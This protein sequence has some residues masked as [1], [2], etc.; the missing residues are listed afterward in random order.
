MARKDKR[1]MPAVTPGSN[2]AQRQGKSIRDSVAEQTTSKSY[3][4]RMNSASDSVESLISYILLQN[5]DIKVSVYDGEATELVEDYERAKSLGDKLVSETERVKAELQQKKEDIPVMINKKERDI[6]EAATKEVS[7]AMQAVIDVKQDVE[8]KIKSK[9]QSIQAEIDQVLD[10][11]NSAFDETLADAQK[12]CD[13]IY[14]MMRDTHIQPANVKIQALDDL[15]SVEE[16]LDIVKT[17]ID[18]I[19]QIQTYGGVT[20]QVEA[21]AKLREDKVKSSIALS[22]MLA[23]APLSLGYAALSIGKQFGSIQKGKAYI[24]EL[25]VEVQSCLSM[26]I[27]QI[28]EFKSTYCMPDVSALK[29][30]LKN[31][32]MV[33]T[34]SYDKMIKDVEDRVEAAKQDEQRKKMSLAAV[35]ESER[36]RLEEEYSS[37]KQKDTELIES[38]RKQSTEFNS[39]WEK[40]KVAFEKKQQHYDLDNTDMLDMLTELCVSGFVHR[41]KDK[42]PTLIDKYRKY[43]SLETLEGLTFMDAPADDSPDQMRMYKYDQECI[44]ERDKLRKQISDMEAK[45]ETK[46]VLKNKVEEYRRKLDSY[47]APTLKGLE[48]G[49]CLHQP[50]V[51]KALGGAK[52][53]YQNE[54]GN[55]SFLFVYDKNKKGE[56]EYLANYIKYIVRQLLMRYHADAMKVN[57]INPTLS[58]LFNNLQVNLD[59]YNAKTGETK[60]GRKFSTCYNTATE[61]SEVFKEQERVNALR[62]QTDFRT[63]NI[64]EVVKAKR[65]KNANT[66]QYN[67]NILHNTGI[68]TP[69]R[70]FNKESS[71]IGITNIFL[72]EKN[73]LMH[74]DKD[75]DKFILENG[76]ELFLD[77]IQII[78]EAVTSG[79]NK[80]IYLTD[81]TKSE[82]SRFCYDMQ[83]RE[84]ENQLSEKI[85]EK[86]LAIP[87]PVITT[88]EFLP[89]IPDIKENGYWGGN[90]LEM[91]QL[92]FGYIE[93]DE[94]KPQPT[95]LDETD[96]VHMFIGGTTGGGKSNLLAVMVNCLKMMYPPSQIDVI[97]F[98][99]KKVEVMLHARPYKMPHCTAMSGTESPEYLTSLLDFCDKEMTTR[100]DLM[101]EY[102]C[103]KF[104]KLYKKMM[105]KVERLRSEGKNG[106]ADELYRKIPRRLVMIV[107]EAAQAFQLDD[108]DAVE[109]VK[110]TFKRI[111]QL[112]RAAGMHMILVSQDPSKM[113]AEVMSLLKWRGCTKATPEVSK[114]ILYGNDIAGRS[115]SQ[116]VGFFATT[117][118]TQGAEVANKSYV[119]PLNEE[120]T[121]RLY[122]KIAYDMAAK[123]IR[124]DAVI[125]SEDEA[126]TRQLHELNLRKLQ[127]KGETLYTGNNII[128]GEP[129]YFSMTG[130]PHELIL[131]MEDQE[132]IAVISSDAG[133]KET[134][135]KTIIESLD[136]DAVLW[137]AYAKTIPSYAPLSFFVDKAKKDPWVYDNQFF[138][139]GGNGAVAEEDRQELGDRFEQ[140][141]VDDVNTKKQYDAMVQEA[142][143]KGIKNIPSNDYDY[144]FFELMEDGFLPARISKKKK[145]P[146]YIIMFDLEKHKSVSE[147]DFNWKQFA[148]IINTANIT[149][150]HLIYFGSNLDLIND[151]RIFRYYLVGRLGGDMPANKQM[152]NIPSVFCKLVDVTDPTK[153]ALFKPIAC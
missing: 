3:N 36:K 46:E 112:A 10:T 148:S 116:F 119:V 59:T 115:S 6:M 61:I 13:E 40:K 53:F 97:Y 149:N 91:V 127:E 135:Y 107:D 136:K 150:I 99:F 128:L 16:L 75:K 110:L 141:T 132:N 42:N 153:S 138:V 7:T 117:N 87:K 109:K 105:A 145:N 120:E 102:N 77:N 95:V 100:Y 84:E 65:L 52:E 32:R 103:L 79:N 66:P 23:F 9:E 113:P 83:S 125:F 78:G 146:I 142:A 41:D 51:V 39:I 18:L 31:V 1:P 8:D 35:L 151:R 72:L 68:D 123:D 96:N 133:I 114:S 15:P 88:E 104:S 4:N 22:S 43:N 82:I 64:D 11:Y 126:Y 74:F 30:E 2:T 33:V 54:F 139:F 55:G 93:G 62:M 63:M 101:K 140:L 48:S 21:L 137:P 121:T 80:C 60:I 45:G 17:D 24:K 69:F 70:I 58:T 44:A 73:T 50:S 56:E 25:E 89:N 5:K 144:S 122:S 49:Y 143:E 94:S 26:A 57:I 124:R 27:K 19:K 92:Y 147:L 152:R 71:N 67:V 38:L 85:R 106:E 131:R 12:C 130:R 29:E 81:I 37:L 118:D 28:N 86:A 76:V 111:A 14:D 98:D 20:E 129:C 108:T 90:A 34:K 47:Y 134:L